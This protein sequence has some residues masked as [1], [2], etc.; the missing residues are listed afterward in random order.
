MAVTTFLK[1]PLRV[2]LVGDD[3][4]ATGTLQREILAAYQPRRVLHLMHPGTK[5]LIEAGFPEDP[6][7]A[8]YAC[9]GTQCSNPLTGADAFKEAEAF[10]VSVDAQDDTM[11][12]GS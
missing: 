7:P 3:G 12:T 8:I 4:E 1:G 5:D 2:V 11:K 10:L 9:V 6:L